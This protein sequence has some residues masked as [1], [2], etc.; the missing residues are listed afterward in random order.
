MPKIRI[1][2]KLWSGCCPL[3]LSLVM[4]WAIKMHHTCHMCLDLVINN[5]NQQQL[6]SGSIA[7]A[8]TLAASSA[9]T[10]YPASDLALLD[11]VFI[12]YFS[13][14]WG[15]ALGPLEC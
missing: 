11:I 4:F 14:V 9:S 15:K 12:F 3:S 7:S 6:G 1:I 2:N 13:A 8:S 10:L 5:V